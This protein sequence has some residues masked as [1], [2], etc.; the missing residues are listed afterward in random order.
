MRQLWLTEP[1]APL[2]AQLAQDAAWK[3]VYEDK[4]AVVFEMR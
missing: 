4:Q 1:D 2:T 3:Q